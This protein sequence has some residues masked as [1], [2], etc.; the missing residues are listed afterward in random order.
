MRLPPSLQ[1]AQSP[2]KLTSTTFTSL[3]FP[4]SPTVAP[5]SLKAGEAVGVPPM[6]DIG[7][8]EMRLLYRYLRTSQFVLAPKTLVRRMSDVSG[9]RER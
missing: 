7:D 1:K 9:G 8:E 5:A 2:K 6:L 4:S 3:P